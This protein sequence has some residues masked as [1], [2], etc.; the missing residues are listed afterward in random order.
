[1]GQCGYFG[2]KMHTIRRPCIE[3]FC[4]SLAISAELL[5]DPVDDFVAF[6][7][8]GVFAAAED[9]RKDD[10]VLVFEKLLGPVDLGHQIVFADLGAQPELFVFAVMSVAFV[11]PLFLLVFELAEVHDAADGRLLGRSNFDQ[12]HAG[13]TG[14]LQCFVGTDDSQLGSVMSNDANR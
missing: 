2:A 8:V 11:L 9:H 14:L 4:S 10:L 3:G 5:S 6:V 12:I 7:D 13:G 1:M